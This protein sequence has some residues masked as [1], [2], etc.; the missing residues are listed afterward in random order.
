MRE[1]SLSPR[2]KLLFLG[3]SG[4][5]QTMTAS[6]LAGELHLPLFTIMRTDKIRVILDIPER[7][8]PFFRTGPDANKVELQIPAL[9]EIGGT[10]RIQGAITRLASASRRT[11]NRAR[12]ETACFSMRHRRRH[13]TASS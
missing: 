11:R 2:R 1:H 7:D 4:S 13:T 5:G 10:D 9:K 8:V 6:A 12:G 3:P